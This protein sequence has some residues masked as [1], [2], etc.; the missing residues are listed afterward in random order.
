MEVMVIAQPIQTTKT[1]IEKGTAAYPDIMQVSMDTE[2]IRI[3]V[4]VY[5]QMAGRKTAGLTTKPMYIY[6]VSEIT[7]TNMM[8]MPHLSQPRR[9]TVLS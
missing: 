6:P 1:A 7:Q 4:P 8:A 2:I 5:M 9:A 3:M